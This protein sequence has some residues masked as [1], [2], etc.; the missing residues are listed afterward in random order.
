MRFYFYCISIF[1]PRDNTCLCDLCLV[2]D[3]F[4]KSPWTSSISS[5]RVEPMYGSDECLIHYTTLHYMT[6][7]VRWQ[8]GCLKTQSLTHSLT[9]S[10]HAQLNT[11]SERGL[12]SHTRRNRSTCSSLEQLVSVLS[13]SQRGV[14]QRVLC[15]VRDKKQHRED[16]FLHVF[17]Y[18]ARAS[19][20]WEKRIGFLVQS[21]A[22]CDCVVFAWNANPVSYEIAKSNVRSETRHESDTTCQPVRSLYGRFKTRNQFHATWSHICVNL[23]L[24]FPTRKRKGEHCN[25]RY[26][27]SAC[28]FS[29]CRIGKERTSFMQL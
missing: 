17:L 24:G 1:C 6:C 26:C 4:V 20:L 25:C 11:N 21:C 13:K 3:T 14:L 27:N 9:H 10:I 5:V 22:D 19:I 2:A 28:V 29:F 23:G 16:S 15:E 7:A 12:D 8:S 18:Y